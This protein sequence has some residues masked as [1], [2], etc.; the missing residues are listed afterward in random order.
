MN[1]L[2]CGDKNIE[3]G[4]LISVLSLLN[5]AEEELH[6]YV[7]TMHLEYEGKECLPVR[8]EFIDWLDGM[9]REKNCQKQKKTDELKS[10]DVKG[11]IPESQPEKMVTKEAIAERIQK[12]GADESERWSGMEGVEKMPGVKE[13]FVKKID[14]SEEF[15]RNLP[16]PNMQTRF[17]P[18]CMLRLFADEIPELPNRI[19]YLDTDIVC[20]RDIS[21]FY[22]QDMEGFELAGVPDYYGRWFFHRK[23]WKFWKWDYLNSGVLLLNMEEIRK[24]G[25]FAKC[26][27]LCAAKE[28]FMPDQSAL[29]KLATA[30]KICP[31]RFNDQRKLHEDTVI[32]HFTTS[33]RFFPWIRTVSVKP[34]DVERMHEVLKLHE[35]DDLLEEYVG[36]RESRRTSE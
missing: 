5:T 29:N 28:M 22:H 10:A 19:L 13:S 23:R 32:Q 34:W 9:V 8:D 27:D 36:L 21:E 16:I 2:Y 31:R 26:R 24:T 6:I 20:R 7:L 33:F 1:I 15:A 4:L 25:L 17:T 18:C 12:P 35:Y 14:L 11:R 30:K 3:D